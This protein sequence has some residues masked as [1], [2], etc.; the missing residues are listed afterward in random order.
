MILLFDDSTTSGIASQIAIAVIVAVSSGALAVEIYKRRGKKAD[1]KEKS[2][3]AIEISRQ[4][5]EA[6]EK[7]DDKARLNKIVDQQLARLTILEEIKDK[8]ASEN[9][10]LQHRVF[11]LEHN[12]ALKDAQIESLK[13]QISIIE[14]ISE[15]A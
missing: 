2:S 7:A 15:N 6:Q 9:L 14:G 13:Q 11:V 10:V 3:A 12:N 1:D 4:K 5:H 8:M